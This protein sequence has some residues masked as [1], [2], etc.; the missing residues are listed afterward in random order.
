MVLD[1]SARE[2]FD[3]LSLSSKFIEIGQEYS[4]DEN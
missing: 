3:M 4:G 1:L 2:L